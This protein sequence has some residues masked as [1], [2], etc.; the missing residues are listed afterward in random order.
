MAHIDAWARIDQ[1]SLAGQIK[2]VVRPLFKNNP[3]FAMLK[4]KGRMIY[5]RRA[6]K[7][8]WR[9]DI[10]MR[11]P[12]TAGDM[13]V[14]TF[15][16]DNPYRTCSLPNRSYNLGHATSKFEKLCCGSTD[17]AVVLVRWLADVMPRM[18]RNMTRHLG[19]KIWS[20]GSAAGSEDIH[21]F[22]SWLGYD[23]GVTNSLVAA[24]NDSYADIDTTLQAY[25]GAW[26]SAAGDT[27]AWPNGQ[28]TNDTGD[29]EY[30][31]T[32]PFIGDYTNGHLTHATKTWPNTW[33]EIIRYLQ[34]Y[35]MKLHSRTWDTIIVE[36]EMMRL[37]LDSLEANERVWIN[38]SGGDLAKLGFTA[39]NINGTEMT[40]AYGVPAASGYLMDW[41]ALEFW[42]MQSKLFDFD[43]DSE[44]SESVDR[45]KIDFWGNMRVE[46]PAWSGALKAIG[47]NT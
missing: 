6:K 8:D 2:K 4:Q 42:S 41:D 38:Q 1:T 19:M 5:N 26:T 23:G 10:K 43:K 9:L 31:C 12:Q 17:D 47:A 32:T 37:A 28:E 11:P 30:Y 40:T 44:I 7:W 15:E 36:S 35:Y 33:R 18:T 46:T 22:P 29:F 25:G 27:G 14:T 3:V 13:T 24:T 20:D 45:V 39:I 34:M 21:G 16:R